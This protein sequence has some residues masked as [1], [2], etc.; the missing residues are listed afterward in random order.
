VKTLDDSK[1]WLLSWMQAV[2][3][4]SRDGAL[5]DRAWI[6]FRRTYEKPYWP[7]PGL[8][9][10]KVRDLRSEDQRYH[11]TTAKRLP[12]PDYHKPELVSQKTRNATLKALAEADVMSRSSDR[13][14]AALGK[15]LVSLGLA[16]INRN[17]VR[18]D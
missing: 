4:E 5:L 11:R 9:C 14:E 13:R 1:T 12:E 7:A 17:P 16:F 6:E 3:A 2:L 10:A 18:A 15:Q 8:F